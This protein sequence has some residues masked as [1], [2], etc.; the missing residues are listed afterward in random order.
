MKSTLYTLAAVLFLLLITQPPVW[1]R[2]GQQA[3]S[4]TLTGQQLNDF[5][6]EALRRIDQFV[7]Y[8]AVIADKQ[9]SFEERN[10][11]IKATMLMFE[12][13]ATIEVSSTTTGK[14]STL[15]LRRY[16]EK[17]KTLPYSKV[18]ISNFNAARLSDWKKQPDGSYYAVGQYFQDFRAW[19][20]GK[21]L[22]GDRTT[23]KIDA[24]LRIREDPFFK[25]KHWMV[26]FR[27]I[28]VKS[29]QRT[30]L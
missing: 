9:R 3:P 26:L 27:N 8:L 24:D 12:Q 20:D 7:D 14:V 5:H 25:D 6:D 21:P 17:L 10:D 23:K 29:S 18:Q 22:A 2:S 28:T 4:D 13:N 30:D 19:R 1:A 11:A 16:L 15:P